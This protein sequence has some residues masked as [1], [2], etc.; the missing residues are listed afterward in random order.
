MKSRFRERFQFHANRETA[1]EFRDQ[2]AGLRDVESARRDEQNM[3]RPHESMPSI[4][5]RALHDGQN[6]ALHAFAADIGAVTAFAAGDLIDLVQEDDAA[7][8]HAIQR[9]ARHLI[10]VDELLL[11]FLNQVLGAS[12]TR[13]L[14]FRVRCPNRPGG[15]PS[16]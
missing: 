6:V 12:A 1:L 10:H 13:I 14:R 3:I 5:G 2:I 4:D 16:D 11:F 15:H 8:L 7:A 9:D